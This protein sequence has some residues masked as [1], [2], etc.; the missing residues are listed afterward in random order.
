MVDLFACPR[1]RNHRVVPM[2]IMRKKSHLTMRRPPTLN[3]IKAFEAALR[4]GGF[5]RA[6]VGFGATHG[7]AS[8]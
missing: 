4:H 6:I 8:S 3:A 5:T 2:S 1:I 7:A